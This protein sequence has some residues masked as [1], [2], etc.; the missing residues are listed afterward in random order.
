M[1]QVIGK[2]IP[3]IILIGIG[4]FFQYRQ[5]VEPAVIDKLKRAVIHISLPA[6]LFL[7]FQ[8]M[9]LKEAYLLITLL[10]VGMLFLFYLAGL[11]FHKMGYFNNRMVPF[12]VSG[13]SFG[14]LAI[15]LFGAVYGKDNLGILSVLGVGHELYVWL[16]YY[17]L[18]RLKFTNQRFEIKS[19]FDFL[20]SPLILAIVSGLIVNLLGWNRYFQTNFLLLGLT[21]TLEYLASL[22][23]PVILIIIGYGIR[24]ERRYV[25]LSLRFV[26][27]RL[28]IMLGI[29][30]LVK[31]L[32]MD[33]FLPVS[34]GLFEMAYFTF[35]IMPPPFSLAIFAGEYGSVEEA[36]IV[37][38]T[39]VLSTIISVI[40]F[41]GAV[42]LKIN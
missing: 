15:P 12:L 35:L 38:N 13:Y 17:T 27:L 39:I 41:V 11:G 26:G 22:A 20:K 29:G 16:V 36:G 42:I 34:D 37:N 6:V 3:I 9:E 18:F 33:R 1:N 21:N 23:T 5:V 2:V 25:R 32:V 14:L 40:M 30:Y 31:G 24:M 10:V 4:L 8:K 19:L 7:T 28:G